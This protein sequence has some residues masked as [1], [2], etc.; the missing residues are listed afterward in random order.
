MSAAGEVVCDACGSTFKVEA[1]ATVTW[2]EKFR[3][4]TLGRFEL[5]SVVGSGGFGTVYKARDPR[6]DRTVA[7]KVP[8]NVSLPGGQEL[9]RFLREARATAQL[10]H[11]SIVPGNR[12]RVEG[13]KGTEE[14]SSAEV[15]SK[16][17]R[18]IRPTRASHH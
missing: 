6:L 15:P 13:D 5:L 4:R 9:D 2:D 11:P 7:V 3:G 17:L 16:M 14:P 10:R 12:S 18:S 1:D 8:R